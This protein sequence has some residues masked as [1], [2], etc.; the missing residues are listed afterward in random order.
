MARDE[1][2]MEMI[3]KAFDFGVFYNQIKSGVVISGT[4][5][6]NPDE[7]LEF[8]YQYILDKNIDKECLKCGRYA[9]G[10]CIGTIDRKRT[11]I[12]EHNRCAAFYEVKKEE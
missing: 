2:E 10:S 7:A 12:N 3:R 5:P 11:E 6:E 8:V 1:R 4:F 9:S